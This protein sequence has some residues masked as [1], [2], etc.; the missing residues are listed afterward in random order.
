MSELE[1]RS[2]NI[3]LREHLVAYKRNVL[4]ITPSGTWRQHEYGH[5][6]PVGRRERNITEPYRDEFWDYWSEQEKRGKHLHEGFPH[7]NS[8]QGLCFNLFFPFLANDGQLVGPLSAA[9]GLPNQTSEKAEFEYRAPDGSYVDFFLSNKERDA[10]FEV[11]LSETGFGGAPEDEEHIRKVDRIYAGRGLRFMPSFC[12]RK[13]FLDNYQILRTIWQMRLDSDDEIFFVYP[14]ANE[15][16]RE[17][18]AVIRGC[19]LPALRARVHIVYLEDLLDSI[20]RL[21][22]NDRARAHYRQFRD[23]YVI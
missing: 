4:G 17:A 3:R 8:S 13:L 22:L 5:I 12:E 9:L 6:L 16:L 10:Y 21:R 1:P 20:E 7:L 23:K 15:Y 19:T 2:Y 14:K 11:K 18:E